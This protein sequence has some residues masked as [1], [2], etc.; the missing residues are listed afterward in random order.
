MS[1]VLWDV[2][3]ILERRGYYNFATDALEVLLFG[4]RLPRATTNKVIPDILAHSLQNSLD[5]SARSYRPLLSRRARGKGFDRLIIDYTH[6]VRKHKNAAGVVEPKNSERRVSKGNAS[7]KAKKKVSP[8]SI[9]NEVVTLL[10]EPIIRTCVPTG[11]IS[12]SSIR[13]LARRLKRPLSRTLKGLHS[14]ET[15]ELGHRLS[16]DDDDD[17][18]DAQQSMAKYNDWT[19]IVDTAVANAMGTDRDS[20][21]GRCSFIGFE[22][23]DHA[24]RMGSVNVEELAKEYYHQGRLPLSD[25]SPRKGGWHG[26]H[27]EGGKIRILFRILSSAIL[28]MDWGSKVKSVN[29]TSE[30]STIHLTPYQGAP[31]DLHVGA[32]Q[33]DS[34]G[35]GCGGI[36][37]RRKSS[38]DDFLGK[39]S[40]LDGEGLSSFV[41]DSINSRVWYTNSLHRPDL[42]LESDL[43]QVRTLSMVA[44]GLGGKLLAS[45][46]R[47][48]FFDYRHYSG[49]LPDLLLVRALY[50]SPTADD[51]PTTNDQCIGELVDLG[52]WIGEEFSSEHQEAIKAKQVA[53][54]L[55]DTDGDFLGCSKVGD[56]GGRATNRFQRSGRSRKS[57]P[58]NAAIVKEGDHSNDDEGKLSYSMPEKLNFNHNSRQIRVECMFVEVKSQ[59]DRLDSRQE[60][61]LNILDQHGNAR[62][63]KFGKAP[64]KIMLLRT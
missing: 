4:K 23:D 10:T 14:F 19:P 28:G 12:F 11:Q 55:M 34:T 56:S 59:N 36:Y 42:V 15:S 3:P 30:P 26:Y 51:R 2:I 25:V 46:F 52:D 24:V 54:I 33:I 60:D 20:V 31:F 45:I 39:L 57:F 35:L 16:N 61:W 64:K 63:C 8:G 47:C 13:T 38:I 43:K 41:Y 6:L 40:S 1:Y 29:A 48:L 53:R 44:A 37:S 50:Y 58:T 18:D 32:E 21:G 7:T 22:E 49:G 5:A 9:V 27:D 62:V 17:D